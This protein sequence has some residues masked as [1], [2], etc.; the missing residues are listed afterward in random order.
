MAD[1]LSR[2]DFEEA[3]TESCEMNLIKYVYE[4]HIKVPVDLKFIVEQQ[5]NNKELTAGRE[6]YPEKSWIVKS[7]TITS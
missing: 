1:T 4:D 7:M 5:L 2:L 3:T 6:K